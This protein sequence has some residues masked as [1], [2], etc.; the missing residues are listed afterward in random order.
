MPL[1]QIQTNHAPARE[2]TLAL[3]NEVSSKV[4]NAL[5]KPEA[6][7]MTLLG[8][9][10]TMTFG[11]T[12]EPCSYIELKNIGTL[13]PEQTSALSELLCSLCETHLAVPPERTYVEFKDAERHLWGWNNKTFA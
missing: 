3:L 12:P 1:I 8:P 2:H 6:Y 13:T 10:T 4:A 9:E 7:V 11:G 5:G